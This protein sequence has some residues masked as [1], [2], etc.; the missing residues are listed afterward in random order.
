MILFTCFGSMVSP[1]SLLEKSATFFAARN[2]RSSLDAYGDTPRFRK[3]EDQKPEDQD[4]SERAQ[5]KPK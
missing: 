3:P 2:A 1:V 5:R 4:Q